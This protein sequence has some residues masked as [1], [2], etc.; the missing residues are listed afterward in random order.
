MRSPTM[1][2]NVCVDCGH[3]EDKHTWESGNDDDLGCVAKIGIDGFLKAM[4]A[5]M[6]FK[7]APA[8]PEGEN[9]SGGGD[10]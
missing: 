1:L 5:C 8:V 3:S 10:E 7:D 2:V 6:A 4:C 9:R